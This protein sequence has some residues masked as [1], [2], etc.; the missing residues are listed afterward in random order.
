M[1]INQIL[2]YYG[3]AYRAAQALGVSRQVI[4]LWKKKSNVPL[5]QQYRYEKLTNG[6]LTVKD[7]MLKIQINKLSNREDKNE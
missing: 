2:K 7:D 1:T 6:K 3:S 4:S 5:L